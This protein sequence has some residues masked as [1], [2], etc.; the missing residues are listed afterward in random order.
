MYFFGN[1]LLRCRK[2]SSHSRIEVTWTILYLS[3]VAIDDDWFLHFSFVVFTII[4]ASQ[5]WIEQKLT[6]KPYWICRPKVWYPITSHPLQHH[7][8]HLFGHQFESQNITKNGFAQGAGSVRVAN[9]PDRL[10]SSTGRA[11][12][13]SAVGFDFQNLFCIEKTCLQGAAELFPPIS[14][15]WWARCL[16]LPGAGLLIGDGSARKFL[17]KRFRPQKLI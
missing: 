1:Q 6:R 11:S 15:P 16:N 4:G 9:P 3:E 14:I 17:W 8:R 5:T 10:R 12:K 2:V 7:L 13:A